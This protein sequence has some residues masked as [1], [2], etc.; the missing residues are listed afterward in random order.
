MKCINTLFG[1]CAAVSAVVSLTAT[2][3]NGQGSL[4]NGL[5]AYYPFN[6][7]GNDAGG[8]GNNGTVYGATPAPNR[9]G[10]QGSAYSFD[11]SSSFVSLPASPT[12]ATPQ[13]TL[14]AW[15]AV[16]HYVNEPGGVSGGP[17]ILSTYNGAGQGLFFWVGP[18]GEAR[19]RLATPSGHYELGSASGI[20]TSTWAHVVA[21]FD[22]T[23]GRVFVNG[24]QEGTDSNMS[25][26]N[27]SSGASPTIGKASWYDGLYFPGMIDDVRIY[28][29]ALSTNEVQQL[30]AYE[31][32]PTVS[33]RKAL[34]PSFSNLFLSTNYQ[35]QVSTD[36]SNWTNSGSAFT[37]TNTVMDYPHYFDV[38]DWAQLFFRLQVAP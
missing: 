31:S 34:K 27:Y 35:L 37:P 4:S 7:N 28:S 38:D 18:T 12:L 13:F 20:P 16:G 1:L 19:L 29:R 9:F 3:A 23:T 24:V 11:G 5:V 10:I 33:L 36:L 32:Q 25:P 17:I 6:G 30:Y 15:V 8:N 21:S 14:S 2:S 26:Y 22:G